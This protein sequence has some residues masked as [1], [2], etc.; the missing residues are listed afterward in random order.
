MYNGEVEEKLLY[1][2]KLQ[3]VNKIPL[4]KTVAIQNTLRKQMELA[5]LC[6]TNVC[7]PT[8]P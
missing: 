3:I 4:S 6:L 2:T 7:L 5:M 1:L 8:L